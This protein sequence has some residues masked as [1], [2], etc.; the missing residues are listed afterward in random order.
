MDTGI[1]REL[2]TDVP[3]RCLQP[4]IKKSYILIAKKLGTTEDTV[5][6]RVRWLHDRGIVRGWKLGVNPTLFG[7]Q[8]CYLFF[9]SPSGREKY[10]VL[11]KLRRISGILW[12]VDYFGN[13][14][15]FLVSYKDEETLERKLE[16]VSSILESNAYIRVNN[17]FPR[18]R[19]SLTNTDWSIIG[20][21]ANDPR[22][23][24]ADIATELRISSRMAKRRLRMMIE[25]RAFFIFPDIDV[26]KVEGRTVVSL[27]AFYSDSKLKRED[28]ET[29][30]AKFGDFFVMTPSP[31]PSYGAYIFMLPNL[32]TAER[33]FTFVSGLKGVRNASVRLIVDF[34]NLL[35]R[36]FESELREKGIEKPT[37]QPRSTT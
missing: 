3:N 16:P 20:A 1:F 28:E 6:N 22:K 35:D 4:D 19:T 33:L 12:I 29:T 30:L 13:F 25:E 37:T 31:E 21:L 11:G 32:P 14:T 36:A 2:I 8:T 24:Y 23:S 26:S 9:D 17:Q 15:G 18:V 7:Y 10:E 34:I 27:V 5:R